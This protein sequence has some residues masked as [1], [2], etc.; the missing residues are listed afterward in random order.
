M[1]QPRAVRTVSARYATKTSELRGRARNDSAIA[2]TG[3]K[4]PPAIATH[5]HHAGCNRPM[6]LRRMHAI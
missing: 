5:G 4:I 3:N 6:R 1:L 2:M